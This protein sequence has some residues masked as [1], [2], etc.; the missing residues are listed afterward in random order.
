MKLIVGRIPDY[1]LRP[2]LA[3]VKKRAANNKLLQTMKVPAKLGGEVEILLSI[4]KLE[5]NAETS[6]PITLWINHLPIPPKTIQ[7]WRDSS[8]R[9]SITS[10]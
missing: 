9:R 7:R 6:S 10:L 3:E 2:V 1:K 5:D 4:T 8:H